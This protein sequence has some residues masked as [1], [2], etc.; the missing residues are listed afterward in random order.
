MLPYPLTVATGLWE[1]ADFS[2]FA[3]AGEKRDITRVVTNEGTVTLK[4]VEVTEADSSP[5]CSETQ[6]VDTLGAGESYEC[7]SVYEV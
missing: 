1:D 3:H 5:A 2:G 6:P 4:D 7:T